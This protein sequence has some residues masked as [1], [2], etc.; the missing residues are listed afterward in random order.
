MRLPRLT[1]RRF[2]LSVGGAALVTGGYTWRVE[3]HW[4]EV[5]ERDLPIAR[6]PSTLVGKKLVQISDLHIGQLVDDDYISGQIRRACGLGDLL[7]ITG[8]FM[9]CKGGEEIDHV[10]RVLESSLRHPPLGTY[11]VLGNHDYGKDWQTHEVGY[12]LTNRLRNLGVHVLRNQIADVQGLQLAGLDD[13]WSGLFKP[14]KVFPKLDPNR[15]SLVLCHNPDGADKGDWCGYRGWVLC[16][17]T[18]GGQCKPPFL[19][20]PILPVNNR[21]Y[22][23]GEIPLA[24]GRRLYINRCLGYIRRVRFNARPE[25]TVFTLRAA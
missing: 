5:V 10:A 20:P 18:H 9:S 8:D 15:A 6:L 1:R 24:D 11:A 16:G 19:N 25:I 23:T 13:L 17:H 14:Q 3:P 22:T 7:V 2:L 12:A 21:R 4:V